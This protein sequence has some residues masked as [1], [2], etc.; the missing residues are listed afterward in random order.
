MNIYCIGTT[1]RSVHFEGIVTVLQVDE[2]KNE[3]QV[4]IDPEKENRS[5]WQE[6]WN[7]QHAIWGMRKREYYHFEKSEP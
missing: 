3:L 4:S 2:E 1:F 5:V 7:L 6:T